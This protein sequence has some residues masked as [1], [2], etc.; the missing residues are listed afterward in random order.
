MGI[1]LRFNNKNK[2]VLTHEAQPL[3]VSINKICI[4]TIRVCE[5]K[6]SSFPQNKMFASRV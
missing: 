3:Q 6:K 1:N 2:H 4:S 5:G